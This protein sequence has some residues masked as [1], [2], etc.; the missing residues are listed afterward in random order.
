MYNRSFD[1]GFGLYGCLVE[2]ESQRKTDGAVVDEK[3][4]QQLTR[5][6]EQEIHFLRPPRI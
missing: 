6:Y 3:C 5:N 2:K 1:A 4:D